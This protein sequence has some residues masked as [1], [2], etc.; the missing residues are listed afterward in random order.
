[1]KIETTK[2]VDILD[3]VRGIAVLSV[4]LFHA[5][6]SAYSY[7]ALPWDRL[8]R[9][10]NFPA[11]FIALLPLHFGWIG[12][13]IFFVVSG[14]CI[15]LSFEKQ[16]REWRSFFIRRFFRIYPAYLAA[17]ILFAF[18]YTN[19]NHDIGLQF[20]THAFLIHNFNAD[21]FHGIN[22]SFWTIAIEVQLYLLYPLLVALVAKFGWRRTLILLATVECLVDGWNAAIQTMLGLARYDSVSPE[23]F[24]YLRNIDSPILTFLNASPFGYWFSWSLGA[25][26]ADAWMKNRQL[27]LARSSTLFWV[28]LVVAAYFAR[29]LAPFF[30]TLSAVLATTAIVKYM[31]AATVRVCRPNFWLE[32]LRRAGIWSYSIYLLHQPLLEL[33]CGTLSRQFPAMP[34]LLKLICCLTFCPIIFLIA[35]IWY[36]LIESP[37]IGLGKRIIQGFDE[38]Q[39]PGENPVAPQARE[40]AK[41]ADS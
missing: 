28:L 4:V 10:F 1:V 24:S 37:G 30:F 5:L 3:Y 17:L 40:A 16:G 8:F 13:P 21:T 34:S 32:Q 11:S 35:A 39:A 18:L 22:S 33:M 7:S 14:F 19:R 2:R 26:A 15:H 36:R 31:S 6:G 9:S 23:I 12:V 29:P 27:P 25:C 38:N 20:I 41:V